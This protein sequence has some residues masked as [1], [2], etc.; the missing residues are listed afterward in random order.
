MRFLDGSDG[1]ESTCRVGDLGLILG[2]RRSPREGNGYPLQYSCLRIPWTQEPARLVHGV[3]K[4]QIQLSDFHFTFITENSLYQEM[5]REKVLFSLHNPKNTVIKWGKKD[6]IVDGRSWS[7]TDYNNKGHGHQH[8]LLFFSTSKVVG[9]SESTN[10]YRQ[11]T[12]LCP[13]NSR[14]LILIVQNLKRRLMFC[15]GK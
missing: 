2:L 10:A 4:S 7:H 6:F 12:Y 3:T 13:Q 9:L 14:N 1:K 8:G 11:V 5:L 15:S